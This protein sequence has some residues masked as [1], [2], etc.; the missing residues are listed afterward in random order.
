MNERM[1]KPMNPMLSLVWKTS[2]TD[3][4]GSWEGVLRKSL[5]EHGAQAPFFTLAKCT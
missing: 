2:Q 4:G 3:G 5:E 1:N